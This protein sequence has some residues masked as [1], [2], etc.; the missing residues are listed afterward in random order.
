MGQYI[1]RMVLI[2][3]KKNNGADSTSVR[4]VTTPVGKPNQSAKAIRERYR[5]EE[6]ER[7]K[8]NFETAEKIAK[9]FQEYFESIAPDCVKVKVTPLHG[10]A[11]YASPMDLA[12]YKAAEKAMTTTLGKRPIPTRSGEKDVSSSIALAIAS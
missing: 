5:K 9:Q 4:K 6:Q 2:L 11:P 1:E 10:G 8:K 3:A 12:A 7:T